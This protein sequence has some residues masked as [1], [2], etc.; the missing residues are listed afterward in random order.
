PYIYLDGQDRTDYE[1]PFARF[2]DDLLA[3]IQDLRLATFH[4]CESSALALRLAEKVGGAFSLGFRKRDELHHA[5]GL[6]GQVYNRLPKADP[7]RAERRVEAAWLHAMQ[8]VFGGFG[9]EEA[10]AEIPVLYGPDGGPALIDDRLRHMLTAVEARVVARRY[11]DAE[12][13]L[14]TL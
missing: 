10:G 6:F 14:V 7:S 1:V 4:V 8:Q 2:V 5:R 11:G 12:H 3:R 13:E 9:A